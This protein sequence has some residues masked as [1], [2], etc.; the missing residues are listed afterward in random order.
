M[1]GPELEGRA[2][3]AGV[4]RVYVPLWLS[5][6][7]LRLTVLAVPPVIPLIHLDL[8]LSETGVGLLTAL[9]SLLF[10][11]AA[12]PGAAL[13]ARFGAVPTLVAGLMLTGLAS[14]LR[15]AATGAGLLYATT[16]LMGVGIAIMQPA[17]PRC[18]R[19]WLPDRIAFGTAV[20]SNGWL[21]GEILSVSLTIPYV[22]PLVHG[23]W[24][25]SLAAWSLPVLLTS[26]VVAALAP[27]SRGHA[28]AGAARARLWWPEWRSPLLWRLGLILGCGNSVY[29]CTNFFLPDYLQ[30]T[31][32][33]ATIGT[34][35]TALN[36]CQIP[37]SLLLLAFA[38]RLTRT[39]WPYLVCGLLSLASVL[40]FLLTPGGWIVAWSGLLGFS[41]SALLILML[42]LPPLLSPLEDVH[43]V[44]AGMFVISYSCAVVIPFVSGLVWDVTGVPASGFVPI[45]LCALGVVAFAL[46]LPLGAGSSMVRTSARES[47][48]SPAEG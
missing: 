12:V 2:K 7:A 27:A 10:A 32:R 30:H 15:G 5:G 37:A 24:R 8:H 45:A 20:Y 31:G 17:L 26:A 33:A 36:L 9:P 11:L 19:D 29:F 40:G 39:R 48:R 22:L 14:A 34:A 21:M 13:I 3:L 23:S 1:D 6:V 42:A 18:V 35:L 28:P 46:T 4:F 47:G 16:F 25:L 41:V 44:S 38:E 43:R